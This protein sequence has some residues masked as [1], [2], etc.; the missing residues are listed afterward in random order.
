MINIWR[1]IIMSLA[2][3]ALLINGH[4]TQE[5]IQPW[6]L[7]AGRTHKKHPIFRLNEMNKRHIT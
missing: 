5:Y 2:G 4:T 1:S 3:N 6:V 7:V